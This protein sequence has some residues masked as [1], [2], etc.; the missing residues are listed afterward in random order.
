MGKFKTI[1]TMQRQ[2]RDRVLYF[3]RIKDSI[4]L[5]VRYDMARRKDAEKSVLSEVAGAM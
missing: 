1:K 5:Q 2:V 4:D 3:E